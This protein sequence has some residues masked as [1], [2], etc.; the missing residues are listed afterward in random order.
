MIINQISIFLENRPG[1]LSEIT[2][3]L[4]EA[5]VNMLAIHIAE[6]SEYG[7]IRIIAD[8]SEK[9]L[10]ALKE[11]GFLATLS[12]VVSVSVTD[13]PGGLNAVAKVI[14]EAGINIEYMYSM[15]RERDGIAYMIFRTSEPEALERALVAKGFF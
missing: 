7:L 10:K 8:D 3:E 5:C 4:N 9:A 2:D 6:A 11:N 13:R 14:G 1:Q 12:Q 15:I